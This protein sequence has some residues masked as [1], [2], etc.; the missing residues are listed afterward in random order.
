MN[1]KITLF[2]DGLITEAEKGDTVLKTAVK[3]SIYIP[4]LCYNPNLNHL[5]HVDYVLLKLKKET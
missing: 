4:N 2:I 3:N 5:G 1:N